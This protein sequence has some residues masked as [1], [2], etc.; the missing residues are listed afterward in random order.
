MAV[1]HPS[2]WLALR[3][4]EGAFQRF[5]GAASEDE[6]AEVVRIICGVDSRAQIDTSTE[7]Q[8]LWHDVIRK[9]YQQYLQDPQNQ[10][11]QEK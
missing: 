6:A 2:A 9:P 10:T 5:L 11:T 3:C 1:Q 7:A 4:K 8:T